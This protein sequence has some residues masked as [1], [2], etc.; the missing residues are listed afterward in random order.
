MEEDDGIVDLVD[1]EDDI[2]DLEEP[3]EEE[4]FAVGED[5]PMSSVMGY[6]PPDAWTGRKRPL[7]LSLGLSKKKT[8]AARRHKWLEEPDVLGYLNSFRFLTD[9][10]RLRLARACANYLNHQERQRTGYFQRRAS[11]KESGGSVKTERALKRTRSV[12][13]LSKML[14]TEA[15]EAPG[16]EGLE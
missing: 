1:M 2:D 12:R 8:I 4:E 9:G 5:E 15:A 6:V 16:D 10:D 14:D 3:E 11:K 7:G 13:D